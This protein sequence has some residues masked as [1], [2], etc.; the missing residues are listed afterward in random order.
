MQIVPD[1]PTPRAIETSATQAARQAAV[2]RMRTNYGPRI[3]EEYL[4]RPTTAYFDA[5]NKSGIQR[6]F[7]TT[8]ELIPKGTEM[9]RAPSSGEVTNRLPRNVGDVYLPKQIQSTAGSADLQM[10]GELLEGRHSTGGN[11]TRAPGLAKITA[12]QNLPGIYD[13]N[14]FLKRMDV[15]NRARSGFNIESIL[16]PKTRYVVQGFTP[17][18]GGNPPV[19]NLGAYANTGLGV[20]NILGFLPALMQGGQA[21]QGKL[22]LLPQDPTIGQMR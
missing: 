17:G 4:R 21:A 18:Q 8:N 15:P 12:M 5:I 7:D 10:L 20:A 2:E 13:L 22:N 16:G 14:E 11:Q 1:R 3:I 9:Y 6:F 19:W